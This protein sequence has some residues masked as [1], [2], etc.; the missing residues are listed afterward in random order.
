[1]TTQ[2]TF[3]YTKPSMC[4]P[5][6]KPAILAKAIHKINPPCV[7]QTHNPPSFCNP[8]PKSVVRVHS[9]H[10]ITRPCAIRVQND[11]SVCNP[12]TK[13]ALIV[14]LC[15]PWP[16]FV[17]RVHSAQNQ[18]SL[19]NP[20]A[21]S[22]LGV[23]P[24]AE[25][26]IRVQSMHKIYP[27]CAIH[28]QNPLSPSTLFTKSAASMQCVYKIRRLCAIRA[29]NRRSLLRTSSNLNVNFI[30]T[31]CKLPRNDNLN[32]NVHYMKSTR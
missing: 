6:A 20:F 8:Y 29:H 2:R 9:V 7:I 19:R 16:N 1:M 10:K 30:V 11:A 32:Y 12:C 31:K 24:C 25:S 17:V 26:T 27:P 23:N 4:N 13:S 22:V 14:P 15:N 18:P 3:T 28:T 5:C 21:K